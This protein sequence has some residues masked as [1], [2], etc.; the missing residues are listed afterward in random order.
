MRKLWKNIL[1]I[2]E[3]DYLFI[4]SLKIIDNNLIKMLN[5]GPKN[6]Q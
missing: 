4:I 3:I 5:N 6:M 1:I 2:V